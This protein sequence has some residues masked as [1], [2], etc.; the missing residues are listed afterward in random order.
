MRGWSRGSRRRGSSGGVVPARAGVVPPQGVFRYTYRCGPRACGGGPSAKQAKLW[1]NGW[2]PR[3]RGWSPPEASTSDPRTVVP[4]RAGVVPG[5]TPRVTF[6]HSGPRACGGGPPP[7]TSPWWSPRVRGWSLAHRH[8]PHQPTV[9]P[10]RA[11]VV[12]GYATPTGCRTR[13]PR[14]CGG[15]PWA[16]DPCGAELSWSPRV[17][18]WSRHPAASPRSRPV[19]PAHAGVVPPPGRSWLRA[20]SGPARA[21]RSQRRAEAPCGSLRPPCTG[22]TPSVRPR[23]WSNLVWPLPAV[24]RGVGVVPDDHVEDPHPIAPSR[25]SR[26]RSTSASA[27]AAQAASADRR[28]QREGEAGRGKRRRGTSRF[29]RGEQGLRSVAA[30]GG[31]SRGGDPT[32]RSC[33]GPRVLPGPGAQVHRAWAQKP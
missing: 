16:A 4:A 24:P 25:G 18:G 2:S 28:Q 17:R 12:P 29:P 19:V 22:F 31:K 5:T 33:S 27:Q 20:A 32:V 1:H 30:V 9:V 15:G 3:V 23:A 21:G 26:R 14:A 10:A 6:E 11:G 8:R 13:G 7:R